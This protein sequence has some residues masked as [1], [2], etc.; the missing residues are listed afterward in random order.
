MDPQ[1]LDHQEDTRCLWECG[2]RN[3]S[4]LHESEVYEQNQPPTHMEH[5]YFRKILQISSQRIHFR[6]FDWGSR[7]RR[8]CRRSLE[9]QEKQLWLWKLQYWAG[10]LQT[11]LGFVLY[12][13]SYGLPKRRASGRR[14]ARRFWRR[15]PNGFCPII[16]ELDRSSW[17]LC[18]L[19]A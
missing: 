17:D 18:R 15:T 7:G 1:K 8:N 4:Y 10:K 11:H 13:R 16:L 3:E 5:R 14:K 19:K 12:E 2:R 6:T 9:S